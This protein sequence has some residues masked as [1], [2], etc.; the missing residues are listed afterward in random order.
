MQA[1][2]DL[3]MQGLIAKP[4]RLAVAYS[5]GLD[6]AV[7]LH[8]C[9]T[10]AEQHQLFLIAFHVHHGISPNA[11][12]WVFHCRQQ[13][14]YLE[15]PFEVAHVQLGST[16]DEG[17]EAAARRERYG[18]LGELAADHQIDLLITAHHQDDQ[19]ET[20]LL[21]LLRGTGIAGLCGMRESQRSEKLTGNSTLWLVRPLLNFTRAELEI[22]AEKKKIIYIEDESNADIRYT[23]NALRLQVMPLLAQ[24]FP[25]Y[26]TRFA[27]TAHHAQSAFGLLENLSKQDYEQVRSGIDDLDVLEL[28][29]LPQTRIDNVLR[30]WLALHHAK[31]PGT[32]RLMEMRKQ[33]LHAKDDARVRVKHG[34]I[35]LHRYREQLSINACAKPTPAVQDFIWKGEPSLAFPTFSGKLFFDPVAPDQPG[36]N[37]KWLLDQA[38][39][40][41]PRQ[42]GE[43]LKLA[44]NRHT[45]SVKHHYQTLAIPYWQRE[46]LPFVFSGDALLF[47]AGIG[48]NADFYG[49]DSDRVMIRWVY[50]K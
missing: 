5:G 23:R 33:L 50:K 38:L 46:T 47:A 10:Y 27:R 7:L 30:Y 31:M 12:K 11:D 28:Q 34:N 43:R 13:C 36:V 6:S 24:Y 29:K 21:Q 16:H 41:R 3:I 1:R 19:A 49:A 4:Q 42:G 44:A 22:Y 25:G 40:L 15:I 32:S 2:F 8:L 18:A 26:Q 20:I 14:S 35:E 17:V 48:V 39:Q 9:A 45:R 37:R